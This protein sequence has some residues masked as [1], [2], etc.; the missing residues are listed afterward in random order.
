MVAVEEEEEEAPR[1]AAPRVE[2]HR[3]TSPDHPVALTQ[4]R[5]STVAA[6]PEASASMLWL[7][8]IG[9]LLAFSGV[10]FAGL[11]LAVGFSIVEALVCVI[12]LLACLLLL[13]SREVKAP[14]LVMRE[15]NWKAPEDED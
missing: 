12:V 10:I 7:K 2:A 11:V 4:F 14:D 8:I 6:H 9:A 1:V 5:S 15:S 13:A 3:S